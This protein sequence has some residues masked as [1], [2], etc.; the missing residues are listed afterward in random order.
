MGPGEIRRGPS[1]IQG[2]IWQSMEIHR[3]RDQLGNPDWD[4]QVRA[5]CRSKPERQWGEGGRMRTTG[6]TKSIWNEAAGG[7]WEPCNV[8]WAD[9]LSS[10]K[11]SPPRLSVRHRP[12]PQDDQLWPDPGTTLTAVVHPLPLFTSPVL[13][14]FPSCFP[15]MTSIAS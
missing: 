5:R 10:E 8:H 4:T 1:R 15:W 13:S 14:R 12:I 7:T 11:K 9:Y 2:T 6:G 3:I